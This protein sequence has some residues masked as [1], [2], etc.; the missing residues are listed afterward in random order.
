[1][2]NRQALRGEIEASITELQKSKETP[3]FSM[4]K[5]SVN[6]LDDG[7][8]APLGDLFAGGVAATAGAGA[9]FQRDR[10]EKGANR[11]LAELNTRGESSP[12]PQQTQLQAPVQTKD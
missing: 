5:V 10:L 6:N 12:T 8:T 4:R 7:Q 11:N 9:A 3:A 2:L 1:M